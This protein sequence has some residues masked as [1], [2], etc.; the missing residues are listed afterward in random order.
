MNTADDFRILR[1]LMPEAENVVAVDPIAEDTAN[2]HI[3]IIVAALGIAERVMTPGFIVDALR[4]T[5]PRHQRHGVEGTIRHALTAP[6]GR[7]L[8]G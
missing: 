8:D 5:T 2:R 1:G 6:A 7:E 4:E 3:A